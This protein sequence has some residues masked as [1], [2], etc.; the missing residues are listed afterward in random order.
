MVK[1]VES[2]VLNVR[3]EKKCFEV[4]IWEYKRPCRLYVVLKGKIL[5][6]AADPLLMKNEK[7]WAFGGSYSYR[8]S[9]RVG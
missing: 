8:E 6:V 1:F 9:E 5:Y 4:L 2:Y 3:V 7:N